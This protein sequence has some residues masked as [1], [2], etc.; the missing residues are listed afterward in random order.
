MAVHLPD[1]RIIHPVVGIAESFGN[2]FVWIMWI[3]VLA[4]WIADPGM[5]MMAGFMGWPGLA[6]FATTR[7]G[8]FLIATITNIIAFLFVV[9]GIRIRAGAEDRHGLRDRRLRT[10][11]RRALALASRTSS[12]TGTRWRPST[13]L[14]TTTPSSRPSTRRRVAS[15]RPGTSSTRWA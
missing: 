2:A 11:L 6:D 7:G 8:M 12:I 5:T 4:P 3:Y 1:S 9:F 13:T 14:W 10:D 15:P